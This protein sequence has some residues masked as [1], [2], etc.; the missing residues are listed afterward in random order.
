LT[1]IGR[2]EGGAGVTV[3]DRAGKTLVIAEAGFDHFR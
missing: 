3:L 2:I 1:R